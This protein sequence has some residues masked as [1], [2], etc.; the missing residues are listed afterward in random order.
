MNIQVR[1]IHQS[2]ADLFANKI[3]IIRQE[4]RLA[5]INA[6]FLFCSQQIGPAPSLF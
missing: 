4:R 1:G 3:D 5:K 6:L 2:Q